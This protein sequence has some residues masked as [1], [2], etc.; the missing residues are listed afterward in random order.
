MNSVK[1]SSNHVWSEDDI[2]RIER[3]YRFI[4][5]HRKGDTSEIYQ[6]ECDAEWLRSLVD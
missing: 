2:E 3:I 1:S 5:K 4:W 6:Q